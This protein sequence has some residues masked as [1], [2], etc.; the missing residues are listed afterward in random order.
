[1]ILGVVALPYK[2][3]AAQREYQRYWQIK[4]RLDR[5]DEREC[6]ELGI[7]PMRETHPQLWAYIW[8]GRARKAGIAPPARPRAVEPAARLRPAR[9]RACR[10]PARH[11]LTP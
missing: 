7:P 6:Q 9:R 10:N 3:P 11:N 1:M 2:D 8:P 5:R 4:Y